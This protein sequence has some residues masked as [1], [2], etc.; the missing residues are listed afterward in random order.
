MTTRLK[1]GCRGFTG[2]VPPPL[3]IRVPKWAMELSLG[4]IPRVE[5]DVNLAEI[6]HRAGCARLWSRGSG[7]ECKPVLSAAGVSW[8]SLHPGAPALPAWFMV[9]SLHVLTQF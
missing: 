7:R 1:P 5:K 2:P 3:W 4:M 9:Y 6:N 8:L